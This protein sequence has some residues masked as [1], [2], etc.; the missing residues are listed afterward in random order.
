MRKNMKRKT[1]VKSS[2]MVLLLIAILLIA[3]TYAWFTSNRTVTISS[4]DVNV[5]A[6]SGIQISVDG[7]SW[8]T[9]ITGEELLA[10]NEHTTYAGAVNQIPIGTGAGQLSPV[11]TAGN[12]T[13]GKLDMFYGVVEADDAAG[14]VYKLSA[15]KETDTAGN[16]GRYIAFDVFVKVDAASDIYLTDS[17]DVVVPS[18]SSDKGIKNAARVAFCVLGHSNNLNDA[19]G[20]AYQS[21]LDASPRTIIWEPNY[22]D[23]KDSAIT[24][25]NQNY[26]QTITSSTEKLNYYGISSAITTPQLLTATDNMTQVTTTLGTKA[27]RQALLSRDDGTGK[28][29]YTQ[30]TLKL[31]EAQMAAGVSK[32]RIYMWIEGQDYDCENQA[33]G[34]AVRFDV[35]F[36]I[37]PV[38]AN[39]PN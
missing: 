14:G 15:T 30:G 32:V 34:T 17:S 28:T 16:S 10:A 31:Q 6:S 3:S 21:L 11:S 37:D 13:D 24:H 22:D 5:A 36:T 23:H 29:P 4:I 18:S 7:I 39:L 9:I 38:A 1:N 35:G 8:K 26:G 20:A 2:I 19:T 12:I 25:A 33:S 27:G